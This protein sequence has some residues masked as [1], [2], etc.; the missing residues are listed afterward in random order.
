MLQPKDIDWLNGYE[1]KIYVYVVY[2]RHT[3][4]LGTQ[5]RLKVRSWKKIFHTS[6]SQKK[7]RVTILISDKMDFKDC[8][9]R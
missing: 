6:G 3:S 9:K 1:S 2:K 4:D 5:A 8:Y 7:A